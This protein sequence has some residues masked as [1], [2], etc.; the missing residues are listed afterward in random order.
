MKEARILPEL[1]GERFGL[2]PG[3]LKMMST[4]LAID[5]TDFCSQKFYDNAGIAV[6]AYAELSGGEQQIHFKTLFKDAGLKAGLISTSYAYMKMDREPFQ[7]LLKSLSILKDWGI[8]TFELADLIF[9]H[10]PK[11]QT[12]VTLQL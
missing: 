1:V 3:N 5:V 4:I 2:D 11:G 7:R 6:V 10:T 12:A 8:N 9:Q